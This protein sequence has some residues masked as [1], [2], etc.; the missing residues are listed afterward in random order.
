MI[1]A[2]II[3][4]H[5]HAAGARGGQENQALERSCGGF[6]SKIHAKVDALGMPLEFVLTAGNEHDIKSAEALLGAE[7]SEYLLADRGYDSDALRDKLQ[8]R[9]TEAVIPGKKNRLKQVEYD[10][11]IY[12]ERKVIERFFNRI[13]HFRRV[14]TRYDKTAFM[15]LGALTLTGILIWLQF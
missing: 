15:F 10:T 2:T 7:N 6:S 1:D 9:G 11:H 5:Q 12:K 13:K 4:A 14:A 8:E 3:R